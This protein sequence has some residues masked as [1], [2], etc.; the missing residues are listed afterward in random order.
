MR[1]GV[2]LVQGE[3][4]LPTL[5]AGDCLLVLRGGRV[6]PDDVVVAQLHDRPGLLVVKRAVAPQ[7][8]AWVLASDN[9]GAPGAVG[10]PG[11]VEAVVLGRWWPLPPG[12]LRRGPRS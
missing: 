2:V 7:G 8:A 1:L 12:R 5:R 6:R 4:M 3:S 9:V 11:E 10:G